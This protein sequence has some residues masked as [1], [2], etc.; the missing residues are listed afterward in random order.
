MEIKREI[1]LKYPEDKELN[2]LNIKYV[3]P[4]EEMS[5][6]RGA[7]EYIPIPTEQGQ[8]LLEFIKRHLFNREIERT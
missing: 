6:S 5:W 1:Y 7:G 4:L 2:H 8:L 3:Y